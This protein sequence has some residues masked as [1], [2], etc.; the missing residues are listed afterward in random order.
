MRAGDDGRLIDLRSEVTWSVAATGLIGRSP[1]GESED[2]A[3][4]ESFGETHFEGLLSVGGDALCRSA[5]LMPKQRSPPPLVSLFP[6]MMIK[7]LANV[8]KGNWDPSPVYP[9]EYP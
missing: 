4:P 6:D 1:R 5:D 9:Q 7:M 8:G 3:M 2:V